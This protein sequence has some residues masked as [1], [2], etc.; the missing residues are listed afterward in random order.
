RDALQ[1]EWDESKA[2]KRSSVDLF[3]E[4]RELSNKP[5]QSVRNDGNVDLGLKTAAKTFEAVYEFPYLSHSSMEPLNCV[6]RIGKGECEI[7][8]GAQFQTNDQNAV[9][10]LLDIAPEKVQIHQLYAGGSFGRRANAF[11]DYVVEV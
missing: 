2:F 6:A 8:N 3:A 1:I 9:A 10:E 7:W 5:G 11:S 4:Y